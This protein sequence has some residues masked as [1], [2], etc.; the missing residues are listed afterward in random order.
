MLDNE[1]SL[2]PAQTGRDSQR[3]QC[4]KRTAVTSRVPNPPVAPHSYLRFRI[5]VPK[6]TGDEDVH[7]NLEG[8]EPVMCVLTSNVDIVFVR[9]QSVDRT[10]TAAWRERFGK[11]IFHF[12][13]PLPDPDAR[14]KNWMKSGPQKRNQLA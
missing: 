6:T 14:Y 11:N 3:H 9:G 1:P 12:N 2:G 10:E 5:G 4:L 13:K 7:W 8:R